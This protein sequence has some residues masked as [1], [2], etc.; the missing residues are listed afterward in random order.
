MNTP[1]STII[2][3][4]IFNYNTFSSNKLN[5]RN[6]GTAIAIRNNIYPRVHDN[7]HS[8]L[9]A[10]TID[11]A[12]GPLTIATYYNPP[13][14][15]FLNYIDFHTLFSIKGQ[16]IF[17]GDL[18][19]KNRIFGHKN[20]N[21]TGRQLEYIIN[22]YKLTYQGSDFPTIVNNNGIGIPDIVLTN[23]SFNMNLHLQPG[24]LTPSDH[25]PI[26]ATIS[27][28]PIQVPIKP[29]LQLHRAD[30]SKFKSL[31]S[32]HNPTIPPNPSTEQIDKLISEW[33]DK[34]QAASK[35]SIPTIYNRAAPGVK[36]DNTIEFLQ[37][38]YRTL[39]NS[40]NKLGPSREKY[41]LMNRLQRHINEHFKILQNTMW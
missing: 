16:I 15:D 8:D 21:N 13:R 2:P 39:Q 4:K 23:Q 9:L 10:I 14:D 26:I 18:N 24:P 7:F 28:N 31:L 19:A 34:I 12:H 41:Q 3:Q 25:T 37:K 27:T 32:I 36:S 11:T 35:Q 29:R 6:R 22:R 38:L 20:K 17:I 5:Q 40:I 30:W 33:T 1:K